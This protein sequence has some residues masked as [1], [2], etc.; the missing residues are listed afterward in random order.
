MLELT[1]ANFERSLRKGKFL[2]MFYTDWCP[3]C[4][5]IIAKLRELE[6]EEDGKFIFAKID[7]DVN[8]KAKEYY[9]V[10]FVP[11]VFAVLDGKPLYGTAGLLLLEGYRL[12][13]EELLY[14]YDEKLLE[15]KVNRIRDVV[16]RLM[17]EQIP[18]EP[19]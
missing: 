9:G 17:W 10:P 1:D 4:P 5:I 12:M 13:A 19:Q 18:E 11:L 14:N 8:K 2:F 7:H 3:L 6:Q 15:E 16:D